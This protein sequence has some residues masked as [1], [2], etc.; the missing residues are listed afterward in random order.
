MRRRTG[1]ICSF[2]LALLALWTPV[3]LAQ[4]Y[5]PS[6]QPFRFEGCYVG[7]I[8]VVT[9]ADPSLNDLAVARLNPRT[10]YPEIFY[11]P[12]VARQLRPQTRIFFYFHECAHHVLGHT[13]GRSKVYPAAMEQQAD[14]W[15]IRTLYGSSFSPRDLAI[16]QAEIARYAR[17]PHF[18]L[19]GPQRAANLALCLGN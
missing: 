10:A 7:G 17:P 18:H 12:R 2:G 3:A 8:P 5:W 11:N 1:W 6:D 13:F 9:L 16:L 4:A 15:A 14:C 19:S